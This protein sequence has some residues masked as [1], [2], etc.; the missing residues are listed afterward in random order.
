M[1]NRYGIRDMGNGIRDRG[2]CIK[3]KGYGVGF[4]WL[5]NL[6]FFS[7]NFYGFQ[8]GLRDFEGFWEILRDFQGF[9]RFS[10]IF[11]D[12]YWFS[13]IYRDFKKFWRILGILK[14]LKG[15]G[16]HTWLEEL[17]GWRKFIIIG[18][19]WIEPQISISKS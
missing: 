1:D 19:K 14:L 15:I 12:F 16:I 13:G 5:R 2:Y 9:K 17:L 8:R 11:M 7:V 4:K 18:L 3:E 6:V 10:W